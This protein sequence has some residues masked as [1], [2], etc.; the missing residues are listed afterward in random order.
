[1]ITSVQRIWNYLSKKL[2]YLLGFKSILFYQ[3]I[4]N[5]YFKLSFVYFIFFGTI[6]TVGQDTT[7]TFQFTIP[8]S[9]GN[10]DVEEEEDGTMYFNSTDLELT[11]D[12][13]NQVVGLRFKS[14][15]LP[16]GA[17]IDQ[18]YIQFATDE[19]SNGTC[20][21][22]I[23]GEAEAAASSF[24]TDA[25]DLSNRT[26]T[27]GLVNWSP[28]NWSVIGADGL[29][30]QTP[31]ID[32]IIQEIVNR[33]DWQS[34][35][36]I[37]IIITGICKRVA[38]SFEG[39]QDAAAKLVIESSVTFSMGN[40]ENVYINELM[41]LNNVVTDEYG[42]TDDWLEIYND[43]DTGVMLEGIYISD[44]LVDTTKWQFPDP[45]FISPKSFALIWLDDAPDQ[46]A[47][48]VP[49]KLSSGGETV[50]ISQ[51]QGGE[52]VV[53]DEITFGP[54]SENVSYGRETDGGDSWVYFG[55]YTPDESNNGSDLFL[56]ASID[57]SI[58]GGFYS[59]GT[60]LILSTNEPTA[61][62]RYTI[63]GSLPNQNSLLYN[64]AITLN[65]TTLVR[66]RA[67]KPGYI[68]SLQK[69]EFYLVENAHELPVIQITIDPK[70]LWDDQEGMYI[71]GENGIEGN[72]SNF[73]QRN[74]NQDWERPISVRYFE[75]NGN[76]AFRLDAAIKIAGGCSRAFAMKPFNLFFRDD[77]VEY[78]I[79]EQL[80]FQ[81]FKRLKLR[82][83][84]NDYPLTMVRDASIQ[85]MLYDQVD[86]DLMAY[87]PVVVYLNNEYW[88]F[89]GMREMYN[90]HYIES[91]HGVDK[92]SLDFIKNPYK[93]S[94]IKEGDKIAW[95]E[96]TNFIENN[97]LQNDLNFDFVDSKID[98]NEYMNYNIAEMYSA[99]YDWPANNVAVWRDRNGGKFRWM[100][101]DLDIS[102]GFAQWSPSDA[103]F[104]A[105]DHAT[106]IFGD[107][108]PNN[109]ESTLFL[110][111]IIQNQNFEN[112][113][114]QR[115]CTFG[116][117][118]FSPDRAE[119]FIDSLSSRISS[120]IPGL[121]NKFNNTPTDWYMWNED[122]VGGSN[123]S[124]NF[125]LTKFKNFWENRLDNVL[126][127]YE[128]FFAYNGHF[129]LNI[130]FDET[131]NGTVVFHT[132]EM[133]IPFQYNAKYF[134]NVPIQVKAIPYDGYYFWKWLE[135][136]D[137]SQIINFS[138][139][140]DAVLTPLFLQDGTVSTID[141]EE[142]IV[143]EISP[144]P[145]ISKVYLKYKIPESRDF[146]IRVYNVMGKKVFQEIIT[147]KV[148]S[149]QISID[150]SDWASGVY[151]LKGEIGG[152]EVVEKIVVE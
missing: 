60:E 125:N 13:D 86:I 139:Y 59:S 38:E 124:W 77:K 64:N 144:N 119:H 61:E 54:L 11:E 116:Q 112:E 45:I 20:D 97:S 85:A 137:T 72:C 35:N 2:L 56:N 104:N 34:G 23:L 123:G 91:H 70:Y 96:L 7:I 146:I 121:I 58:E 140:I 133:R 24:S 18:A 57:F 148:L 67:F 62:I 69:E 82:M 84:G 102:S 26:L 21:L 17:T 10:D 19:F 110:R 143:F 90:K 22:Q 109:P 88:G 42:E 138:S 149:Q 14:I 99:N 127:N 27:D 36:S 93:Y 68:S 44:D 25:F 126:S 103:E 108:W 117:T 71:T 145:A 46:G 76:E 92:D 16:Q 66:A 1:M 33:P 132:N 55:T 73:V 31:N 30:Q 63:D 113:F 118:I 101:Y 152:R 79:F 65:I 111:K 39:D 151:F 131:T 87:N 81:E 115:T 5:L 95:D 106:T 130:N 89:Y 32:T 134:D 114:V 142:E 41:S 122:P 128:N 3:S 98:I 12:D 40:I 120:E 150:V 29:D 53:L 141:L 107:D 9:T 100:L 51:Y 28:A 83:S 105:I 15:Q 50:F 49:F 43:N 136:G 78:P 94:E 75:P 147:S 74:W 48:H 135:T 8:I 129:N 47:N 52:L 4:M 6:T 37:N 80:G